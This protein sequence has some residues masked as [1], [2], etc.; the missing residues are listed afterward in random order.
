MC[1]QRRECR[2]RLAFTLIELLVVIAIIAVLVGLLLPAVQK[3]R[4][5]AN[6]M[7]CQNN[8]KQL[9]L[10]VHN[11]ESAYSH[12]P[13]AGETYLPG[14]AVNGGTP[15][16]TYKTQDFHNALT[17]LLP[18]IE[19]GNVYNSINLKLRQNE[20]ENLTNALVGTGFGTSI[21]TFLCPSGSG[22]LRAGT[23]DTGGV[24][25][26][27]EPGNDPVN[28]H[29][30][31]SDYAIV[32]YVEDKVYTVAVNGFDAPN[33]LLGNGAMFYPTMLTARPYPDNY[34]M[35]YVPADPSISGK[36]TVQLLPSAQL[37]TLGFDFLGG[38]ASKIS[39]VTDGL[40]NTVMIYED[41]GRNPNMYNLGT[42][43]AQVPAG[44]FRQGV[45]PNAYLD[46]IDQ[47]PRRN[48]RWGEPDNAS[49]ASGPPN[50]VKT[51]FG[52]PDWCPWNYHDCGPNNEAFSF[53][54]GGINMLFG[55]GHVVFMSDGMAVLVYWQLYTRS[56]GEVNQDF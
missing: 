3:V 24:P 51:P 5:A 44:S 32:P 6:R 2:H 18:Y 37:Q 55:D 38:G 31:F 34:Y 41:V 28:S 35:N 16:V 46:P 49:G 50:N 53:H 43:L 25:Q 42:T 11:F 23:Y 47:F 45:G 12:F 14:N 48:W 54:T 29:Y 7:S 52:G 8:L 1:T 17:V 10:A 21:K 20:G 30:G 15:G 26:S 33:G 40:S 36:K 9:G 39:D 4:E 56:N 27:Y 13:R 19:Q 22:G